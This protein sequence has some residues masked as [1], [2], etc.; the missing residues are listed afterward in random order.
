MKGVHLCMGPQ[1][2]D[3]PTTEVFKAKLSPSQPALEPGLTLAAV[4]P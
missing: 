4:V 3:P 1:I 2:S